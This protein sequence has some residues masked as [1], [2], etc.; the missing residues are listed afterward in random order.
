M[1]TFA[2]VTASAAS[3]TFLLS[4]CGGSSP[5]GVGMTLPQVGSIVI[6]ITPANGTTPSVIVTGPGGYHTVISATQTL[7]TLTPGTYTIRADSAVGP[8]SVV[9]TIIDTASVTGSPAV[10]APSATAQ[11]TVSY[12]TKAHIG[13]LWV[14]SSGGP[15]MPEFASLQ[16]RASALA[17]PAETLDT[18]VGCPNGLALDASGNM[19]ES[20]CN[21]D[22]LLMFTPA[23]RNAAGDSAPSVVIVS[24][25]LTLAEQIAFDSQG[26]LWIANLHGNII[27]FT[28]HQLA[29]GGTQTPAV[30]ISGAA[31]G[32]PFAIVFD[33]S[34]NAWVVDFIKNHLVEYSAAQLMAGGTP[35]PI[36][37]IGSV[38]GSLS[39]PGGAAFECS[40]E[41]VGIEQFG[42][43]RGRV[44]SRTASRRRGAGSGDHGHPAGERLSPWRR[45]RPPRY[46]LGGSLRTRFHLWR[47]SRPGRSRRSA[48]SR[49]RY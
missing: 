40:G 38:G 46:A 18:R 11:V 30:T 44:H 10:V 7:S 3:L 9:G 33:G 35:T 43:D 6:T 25:A 21:S 12:A 2:R 42:R 24:S 15:V 1:V 27:E 13:G 39:G 22:S 41:P 14:A 36:D 37:T 26:D 34:G 23:A 48:E 45:V 49:G 20:S 17:V 31:L 32:E 47:P 4:G 8:D 28:T 19:W 29:A 16:L 5:S